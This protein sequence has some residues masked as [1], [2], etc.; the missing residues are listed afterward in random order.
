MIARE[1]S[2][3]VCEQFGELLGE[4]IRRTGA[5][6][7]LQGWDLRHGHLLLH[8]WT[9]SDVSFYLTELPQ[10]ALIEAVRGLSPDVVHVVGAMT[11]VLV[12]LLAGLPR[13][14]LAADPAAWEAWLASV[15]DEDEPPG[16][17]DEEDAARTKEK[18]SP[19]GRI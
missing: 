3:Q 10:Y 6:I 1:R 11:Y 17:G 9:V 19:I 4:I 13:P 12:L 15:P 7:A 16:F 8:G 14:A 18:R 5:S 2:A